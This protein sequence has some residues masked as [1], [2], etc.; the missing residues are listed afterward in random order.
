MYRSRLSKKNFSTLKPKAEE[1]QPAVVEAKPVK[2]E[3]KPVQS[4]LSKLLAIVHLLHLHMF[5]Q[6]IRHH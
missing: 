2:V 4:I 5:L 3:A 6:G 1:V